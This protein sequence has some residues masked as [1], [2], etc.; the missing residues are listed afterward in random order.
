MIKHGSTFRIPILFITLFLF[1]LFSSNKRACFS[2]Y[3]LISPR[4]SPLCS[5]PPHPCSL[6]LSHPSFLLCSLPNYLF[7]KF[8][9]PGKGHGSVLIRSPAPLKFKIWNDQ[10]V[11][12]Y[13]PHKYSYYENL[14]NEWEKV[15]VQQN[16]ALSSMGAGRKCRREGEA[17]MLSH[18]SSNLLSFISLVATTEGEAG[19]INILSV[20]P[21]S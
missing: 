21:I 18:W 19:W 6:S 16:N 12:R 3:T 2:T 20:L 11:Q 5:P 15:I 14:V 7:P 13:V 8:R 1:S 9:I 17:G 10:A 4:P